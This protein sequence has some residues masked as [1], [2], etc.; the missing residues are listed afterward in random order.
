MSWSFIIITIS[1]LAA[2]WLCYQEY[3]RI[4]KS[5]LWLRILS[6]CVAIA[7]LACIA[8]PVNYHTSISHGNDHEAI[9]L[10]PD[11]EKDSLGN[12]KDAKIFTLDSSVNQEYKN[13][14]L[15]SSVEDLQLTDSTITSLRVLGDGLN[16]SQLNQ[17]GEM[18]VIFQSSKI[19]TGLQNISWNGQVQAGNTLRV[20]GK[21]LNALAGNV[22][23]VLKG[24]N[25]T[26]DS[27][28]VKNGSALNFEL[29]TIPKNEGRVVYHLLAISGKDTIEK[30]DLPVEVSQVKPLKLLVLNTSPD[31][32][33]RFLKNWLTAKGYVAVI[34]SA[35]SKNKYSTEFVNTGEQPITQLSISLLQK[36]DVVVGDLSA[37]KA[38]NPSESASLKEE[39]IQKGLGLIV[40]ADSS[41]KESSWVQAGFALEKGLGKPVYT[42]MA[43]RGKKNLSAKI[44]TDAPY[45]ISKG[46]SQLLVSDGHEHEFAG[47]T[48][49]G[50]GKVVYT[51]LNNTYNWMLAGDEADYS[52]LWS[53]L[54]TE[55][56]RKLPETEKWSVISPIPVKGQK[57]E[58][59]L[60]SS[61]APAQ[62]IAGNMNIAPVQNAVIQFEWDTELWP[63]QPGWQQINQQGKPAKW[64][65]AWPKNAWGSIIALKNRYETKLYA[66]K[67]SLKASVT[68]QIQSFALVPVPKIYFYILFL[69][70][71]IFLWVENKLSE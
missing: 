11:F 25:T 43:I 54:I 7:A 12:L 40:K 1:V 31:F 30:E 42:S 66:E 29:N 16:K 62:I 49:A 19:K 10:T 53:L 2:L 27:V 24:L 38:L 33:T 64:W 58:L 34:R 52:A 41:G 51:S 36:F 21:F 60:Q 50:N 3:R 45:L 55:A 13:A 44:N 35:I 18:P 61:S 23:L 32:E 47:S 15:A 68:K 28:S 69:L 4:N 5:K 46:T 70:A 8:L 56:S 39:I 22:N 67:H 65:Y 71:G 6:I 20:Q 9:L 59:Q 26:L 63:S 37:L 17:L 14:R 48:L 57:T